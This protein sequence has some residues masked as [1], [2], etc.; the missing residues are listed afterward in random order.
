MLD[1]EAVILDELTQLSPFPRSAAADWLDVLRRADLRSPTESARRR[2]PRLLLAAVLVGIIGV[3]AAAALATGLGDRFSTWVSGRPGRP[4]PAEIQQGF[5]AANRAAYAAFPAG[6]KL[7]LLLSRTVSGTRFSLLGFRNGDAYCLRLIRSDHPQAIGA[8]ECLRADELSGVPALV[9]GDAQFRVGDPAKIF[10]GVYGFAT[11]SVRSLVITRLRSS[12]RV[13]AVNNVFLSLRGQRS[14]TVQHHPLRDPVIGVHAL[15]RAG[16]RQTVPY[17]ADGQ[18]VV[19]GGNRPSGPSYFARGSQQPIPG[20]THITAPIT[21]PTIRWLLRREPRGNPLTGIRFSNPSFGRVIQPDPYNPVRIGIAVGGRGALCDYYFAPLTPRSWG[22]GC[23]TWFSLGPIRLGSWFSGPIQHFN[24]FV[25]DGITRVTVYLASGRA[26]RAAL[27]DNVFTIAVSAAEL[28][29]R[30][31]GYDANGKVAGIA[32]LPGNAVL[33]A[34]PSPAFTTPASKL[35]AAEPWERIDLATMQVNGQMIIG[36]T[37]DQ[38]RAILGT[39]TTI[40]AAAQTTNGVAIPEYRYGGKSQSSVGLSIRFNKNSDRIVANSLTYQSPSVV[41]TKLGHILRM[42]P[43]TLQARI[44]K[45]YG[46]R[47]RIYLRY[48]SDPGRGCTAVAL[49]RTSPRGLTFGI[50]PYNPSRPYLV[51][52]AN[53]G[54]G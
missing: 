49:D 50:D 23:G 46:S 22:G 40:V 54:A 11:D 24:G 4:A 31:V 1:V 53:G 18:G 19:P 33:T 14:G 41:D 45:T 2:H 8:N 28:P 34:C 7:R 3:L 44:A 39:P 42:T 9:A 15:M 27:L 43:Q 25:A 20:P 12:D 5:D 51:I 35:P 13:P 30:M 52:R 38:V 37:T 26:I 6:T 17:V 47:Y 16:G 36:K 32:P 48:G 21:K 29:G 10:N